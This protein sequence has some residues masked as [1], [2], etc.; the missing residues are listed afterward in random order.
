LTSIYNQTLNVKE[1]LRNQVYVLTLFHLDYMHKVLC[2]CVGQLT[3][4]D[5]LGSHYIMFHTRT[6][7][8]VFFRSHSGRSWHSPYR[9]YR[10]GSLIV[11][12]E[13]AMT[14]V[15][16][17]IL[18]RTPRPGLFAT[19]WKEGPRRSSNLSSVLTIDS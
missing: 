19:A 5:P 14:T 17:L 11:V 1:H 7:F 12:H 15:S 6:H 13:Y 18:K 9:Y 2:F 16:L 4:F 8:S 3:S 10:F